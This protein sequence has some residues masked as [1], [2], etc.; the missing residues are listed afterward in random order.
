[1]I[2]L[3]NKFNFTLPLQQK[4]L[5]LNVQGI[6][7][8]SLL[9]NP[10]SENYQ[11]FTHFVPGDSVTFEPLTL[12]VL[13]DSDFTLFRDLMKELLLMVDPK[14]GINQAAKRFDGTLTFMDV[15][16]QSLFKLLFKD[17]WINS[18]SDPGLSTTTSDDT[19]IVL[20]VGLIFDSFEFID[21]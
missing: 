12:S 17:C 9:I 7:G 19:G 3:N 16:N 15:K 10:I 14:T 8:L 6:D 20:S 1:M 11:G 5:E 21:E 2:A 13:L 4:D 18:V